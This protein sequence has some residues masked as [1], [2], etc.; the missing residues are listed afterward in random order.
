MAKTITKPFA[1]PLDLLKQFKSDIRTIPNNLPHNGYIVF[2][3]A[4]LSKILREGT[5]AQRL[6]LSQQIDKL[7]AAGGELVVISER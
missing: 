4:M 6:E 1:V 5:A 2:D 3:K 7:G